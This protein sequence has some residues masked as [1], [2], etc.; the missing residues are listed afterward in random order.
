MPT[1][2]AVLMALLE[3][4][5]A[6]LQKAATDAPRTLH[7]IKILPPHSPHP[8]LE[9]QRAMLLCRGRGGSKRNSM[10][11][12]E[13][14]PWVHLFVDRRHGETTGWGLL[15]IAALCGKEYLPGEL[16]KRGMM[17]P[18]K[19]HPWYLIIAKEI[20]MANQYSG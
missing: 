16:G 1:G 4:P 12:T 13:F 15:L 6:K 19:C 17:I 8:P 3:T 7:K 5:L 14:I 20:C 11:Y 18:L 2:D 9:V 10:H